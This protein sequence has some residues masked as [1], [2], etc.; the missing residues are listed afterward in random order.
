M[1]DITTITPQNVHTIIKVAKPV[2]E[3]DAGGIHQCYKITCPLLVIPPCNHYYKHAEQ[4]G[5]NG[6]FETRNFMVI[7]EDEIS[8]KAVKSVE[9]IR[10]FLYETYL[11]ISG[12]APEEGLNLDEFK[13]DQIRGLGFYMRE[14]KVTNYDKPGI[15]VDLT[16]GVNKRGETYHTKISLRNGS[17]VPN[18]THL[19]TIFEGKAFKISSVINIVSIKLYDVLEGTPK[20]KIS[21]KTVNCVIFAKATGKGAEEVAK[22]AE[23]YADMG[24]DLGE[25]IGLDDLGIA[26]TEPTL[27]ESHF[28]PQVQQQTYQPA[29]SSAIKP[30]SNPSIANKL[31]SMNIGGQNAGFASSP[32]PT[33]IQQQASFN[34][35]PIA[36]QPQEL[37]YDMSSFTQ[38]QQYN[39]VSVPQQ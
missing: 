21:A 3:K 16:Q 24:Y 20:P 30:S 13:T 28:A 15:S 31:A 22:I 5:P 36:Q 19:D 8:R 7:P 29:S 6:K 18:T 37:S 9:V 39:A 27:P 4:Q 1:T 32:H 14:K 34:P 26:T 17:S 10:A 2:R 12:K 25:E 38:P 11:R 35:N 33:E 23:Q